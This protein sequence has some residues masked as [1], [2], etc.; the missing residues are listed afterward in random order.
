[1]D[2]QI[3]ILCENFDGDRYIMTFDEASK[4]IYDIAREDESYNLNGYT[5]A[6]NFALF[7]MYCFKNVIQE[8][9]IYKYRGVTY[10]LLTDE[11]I[12]KLWNEL[13]DVP[14]NE[15]ETDLVL[16]E[17]WFIFKAGTERDEI[18]HW[19]DEHHSKGVAYLLYGYESGA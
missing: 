5:S 6:I 12:E 4:E 16:D 10:S 18:W 9:Y 17:D 2:K 11:E 7:K 1:M 8:R 3:M 13:I 15:T 14:F 19:F